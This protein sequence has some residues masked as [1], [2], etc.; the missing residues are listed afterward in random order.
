MSLGD[1]PEEDTSSVSLEEDRKAIA[2]LEP[3]QGRRGRLVDWLEASGFVCFATAT[4]P[5]MRSWLEKTTPTLA[6]CD[7][8]IHDENSKVIHLWHELCPD[9]AVIALSDESSVEDAVDAMHEGAI[10]Y[11]SHPFQKADLD[12]AIIRGLKHSQLLAGKRIYQHRLTQVNHELQKHLN[13]LQLDQQ[14]GRTV[15]LSMLPPSPMTV[16]PFRLSHQI[17]PSLLLSG[18][19]VDYFQISENYLAFYLADVSGHGVGSAFATVLLKNFSRRFRREHGRYMLNNPAEALLWLN[20]R[21]LEAGLGRHVALFLGVIDISTR[22]LRYANAG[23]FP[24]PLLASPKGCQLLKLPGPPL[25]LFDDP[26]YDFG[27]LDLPEVFA[28]TL[29]TDG[30][31]E[32]MPGDAIAEKEKQLLNMAAHLPR[33]IDSVW[34]LL[35]M[36]IKPDE[37]G[38]SSLPDDACCLLLSNTGRTRKR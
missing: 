28:L 37:S 15:Q 26:E 31:L 36:E 21:L 2:V 38:G 11:L 25:G 6:L 13:E 20:A 17:V 32:I 3:D 34:N 4:W 12:R 1:F 10:D 33:D 30:V 19:F 29:F 23:Q 5:E 8:H 24:Y 9:M 35:G 14:A 7:L 27:H 16:G 18:D 22:R